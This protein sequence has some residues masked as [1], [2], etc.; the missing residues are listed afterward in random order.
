M[1]GCCGL[2]SCLPSWK[3]FERREEEG[4]LIAE[5]LR[6]SECEHGLQEAQGNSGAGFFPTISPSPGFSD[7]EVNRIYPLSIKN[8]WRTIPPGVPL[9]FFFSCGKIY[10][11]WNLRFQTFLNVQFGGIK[12]IPSVLQPSPVSISRTFPHPK[13]TLHPETLT[14]HS[15]LPP[16]TGNLHSTFCLF[17][18]ARLRLSYK[19]IYLIFVLLYLTFNLMS[20]VFTHVVACVTMPFLF[21][22]E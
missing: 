11:M 1:W 3:I 17:E 6:S 4:W 14:S 16:D 2:T 18:F 15:L 13:Q 12:Y 10:I 8:D 20:S 22:A 7:P 19:G 5:N 9:F 21:K